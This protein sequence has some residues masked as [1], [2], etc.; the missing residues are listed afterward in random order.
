MNNKKR[1]RLY[2]AGSHLETALF[3]I[4]EVLSDEQD[5]LCNIPENLECS[6]HYEKIENA[7]DNLEDAV[8][9]IEGVKELLS[10]ASQ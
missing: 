4:N 9:G 6:E 2:E 8:D 5:C 10:E 1:Q 7:V 3:I